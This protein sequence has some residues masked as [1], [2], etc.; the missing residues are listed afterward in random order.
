MSTQ[1][2][3]NPLVVIDN[4]HKS[5]GSLEVL[6]GVSFSVSKGEVICVL[7]R[8]GSGKSTLLRCINNLESMDEGEITVD[9]DLIGYE[10]TRNGLVPLSDRKAAAQRAKAA[11]VFQQFNLF[12]HKTVLENLIEGPVHVKKQN[13]EQA[14]KKAG[15][16]LRRIGMIDKIDDYPS[17]LSGG[18]QQ[19]V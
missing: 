19:R 15:D 14:S 12:P 1:R 17:S 2:V 11:M 3:E 18:Q 9:G 4:V 5:F 6:R 7:G 10:R 13:K 8:S 16:I